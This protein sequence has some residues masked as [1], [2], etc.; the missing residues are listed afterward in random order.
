VLIQRPAAQENAIDATQTF[1]LISRLPPRI[2]ENSSAV[3]LLAGSIGGNILLIQASRQE[4]CA[5][6][7]LK[8]TGGMTPRYSPMFFSS[9]EDR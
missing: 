9:K 5:Q 7:L 1:D 8:S 3:L 4:N 6:T 2:F